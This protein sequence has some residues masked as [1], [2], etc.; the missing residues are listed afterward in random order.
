MLFKF[1]TI[2]KP[3]LTP[4]AYSSNLSGM[5]FHMHPKVAGPTEPF[6]TNA[7]S[8]IPLS[9]MFAFVQ[10][11][12][13]FHRCSILTDIT[14]IPDSRM[15]RLNMQDHRPFRIAD[16]GAVIAMDLI[17]FYIMDLSHMN[18]Q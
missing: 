12:Q 1:F 10:L 6:P 14:L 2:G 9:I 16:F 11:N 15:H 4:P 8:I 18:L 3:L 7:A 5:H 17:F 13:P